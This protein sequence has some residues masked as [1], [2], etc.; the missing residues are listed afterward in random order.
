MTTSIH[1][2]WLPHDQRPGYRTPDDPFAT[3]RR[4]HEEDF[5]FIVSLV[6]DA[7]QE[8]ALR[9][10]R[11]LVKS[12]VHTEPLQIADDFS[13]RLLVTGKA[14]DSAAVW[15]DLRSLPELIS[16]INGIPVTRPAFKAR[17]QQAAAT[18]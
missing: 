15:N 9:D 11:R 16:S 8:V 18:L 2:N 13:T 12:A 1:Q 17:S 14:R 6:A 10:I 7:S 4:A 5:S 3:V